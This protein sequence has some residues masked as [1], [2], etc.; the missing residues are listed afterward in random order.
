MSSLYTA[1]KEVEQQFS[2]W[3]DIAVIRN[4]GTCDRYSLHVNILQ[5]AAVLYFALIPFP[6]CG[7]CQSQPADMAVL[8]S[9]FHRPLILS[10]PHLP[11]FYFLNAPDETRPLI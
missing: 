7:L 3:R 4:G 5:K 9:S 6:S 11:L 8:T 1:E 10:S 2:G